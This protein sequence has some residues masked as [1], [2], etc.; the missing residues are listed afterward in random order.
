MG[1]YFGKV[2]DTA[3]LTSGV[4]P[5]KDRSTNYGFAGEPAKYGNKGSGADA[6]PR[7]LQG[8]VEGAG[9]GSTKVCTVGFSAV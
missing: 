6:G 8:G 9:K 7:P 4:A 2:M 3:I 5:G 1:N